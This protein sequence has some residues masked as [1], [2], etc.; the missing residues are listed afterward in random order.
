[1][2]AVE[3]APGSDVFDAEDALWL[4]QVAGLV[5]ELRQEEIPL[6]S[7]SRP[8]PGEKGDIETIIAALGSAGVVSGLITVIQSWLSRERTRHLEIRWQE[9]DETKTITIDGDTSDKTIAEVAQRAM[10]HGAAPERWVATAPCWSRTR[11]STRT[12]ISSS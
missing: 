9:G 4:Q 8:V 2:S 1:M 12:R 6:R 7:E 5:D 3:I 10:E 11:S